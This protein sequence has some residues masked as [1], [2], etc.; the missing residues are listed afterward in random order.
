M[1]RFTNRLIGEKSPYLQQ[2]AHNP[3]DWH[4]WGP[5]AFAKAQAEDKMLLVS[6]GYATCHWCHVMERESFEDERL[7]AYLNAH[8][9][10][11]KV[12]RE[13]RPDVDKIYMDA[14]Q[15][16]GQQGGWPLNMFATP[17]GQPVAGGTYFPP[18]DVHGRRG[19]GAVLE[20]IAEA[21]RD[22]RADIFRN[23]AAL[24]AHLQQHAR[25]QSPSGVQWDHAP[26][27]AA[28]A[29]L[30]Q[31]FDAQQGGFKLQAQNKFPPSMGLML[32]L[33]QHRRT[34][35][36]QAL[37]MVEHTLR[38]MVAGGIYDQLGGG[39]SRYST[40]H[41]W[42][43]PH[44]EKMLYDN[45]LFAQALTE[46][47]LVT[48][49][50]FYRAY[51][52]DVLD[53]LLRDMASPEG[54]LYS[55]EDA[56]SEGEEGRFY[57]WRPDEL[58]AALGPEEAR[59][60]LAWWAVTEQGN[61]EHGAS[62]LHVPRAL[63]EVAAELGLSADALG[64]LL[65]AARMKLLAV[66]ARRVRPLRDDKVLTS[67]DALGISALA[68]AGRAFGSPP[69]LAAAARTAG[70]V[71]D[72][73]RSG[74]GRLLRRYRQGEARFDAYLVDHAQLAVA[75]LDLYEATGDAAWFAHALHLMREVN[76]LFRNP[77]G[78]YFDTG[79]DAERLLTRTMDGYD[80][81]EPSGNSAAALAFLRLHAYGVREG[82]DE[83]AARILAGFEPYLRQAGVSFAAMLCA[84]D[85]SLAPPAEVAIVGDPQAADTRALLDVPA[86]G[87][88]PHAVLATAPPGRVAADAATIPLLEGRQAIGGHATAYV[89]RNMMCRLPVHTPKELQAL[90]RHDAPAAP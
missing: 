89:C 42:L 57:V 39:L 83:D 84:L 64:E 50:A 75:C 13:E 18:D 77:Q 17:D 29:F 81:V 8:F 69:Y 32:L 2:H 78:P 66:R 36:A 15:A 43:V 67:W 9:V 23:A 40:D 73:L 53:Y 33:R 5:E 11:I 38:R 24:T 20:A 86:H 46:A 61:F 16:M 88:H 47:H 26:L 7:A 22:Q 35:D 4:P 58:R 28:C 90:L 12:D 41:Q 63:P 30:A 21:W 14:L 31:T 10:P 85:F 52:E 19:F 56:D 27:D 34:G 1:P 76:R 25:R 59:A 37:H 72:R 80:G 65:H 82:F 62:I 45:A 55:A 79:S 68:R 6:I 74:S 54:A 44:F 49:S 71:L 51:A 3:V 70:F 87:Y 48:G 60:A